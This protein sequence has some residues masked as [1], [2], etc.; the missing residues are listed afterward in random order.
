MVKQV[1]ISAKEL[2]SQKNADL[3]K[4]LKEN[5]KQQSADFVALKSKKA[6]NTNLLRK[7]KVTIARIK[8]VLS[9]KR[10]LENIKNLEK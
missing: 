8:T 5:Y 4:S 1:I 2:R 3:H 9:E 6:T 7:T 10:A